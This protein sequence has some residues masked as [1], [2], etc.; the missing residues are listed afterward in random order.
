MCNKILL[1]MCNKILLVMCNKILL[2]MCNK[3]LLVMC[4]V[5]MLPRTVQFADAVLFALTLTIISSVEN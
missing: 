5:P 1:V 3:I 4:N 2:V